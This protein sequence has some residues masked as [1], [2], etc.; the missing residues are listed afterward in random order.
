M[1]KTEIKREIR[2]AV[3][4][5]GLKKEKG[6]IIRGGMGGFL[7]PPGYPTHDWSVQTDL[8]RRPENRGLMSID[9]A[10]KAEWLDGATRSHARRLVEQWRASRP[11]LSSPQVRD[12]VHQVLGYFGSMYRNPAVPEDRQ[13]NVSEMISNPRLDPVRHADDHAGVHFVREFYP[14]FSPSA[15][16]FEKAHWGSRRSE[17]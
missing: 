2:A 1:N 16:D 3:G 10:T 7:D 15:T 9:S 4:S 6:R 14:E 13:F 11:P 17:A 12:W 5:G 8:R